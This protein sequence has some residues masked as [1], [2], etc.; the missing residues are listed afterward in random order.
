[1]K[2]NPFFVVWAILLL[3]V[4]QLGG[5]AKKPKIYISVDMEGIAHVVNAQTSAGQFDY[6]RGRKLMTAEVNAAIEGCLAAGAEV[7]IV[8]DSHGNAQNIIPE[9]LN[10]KALLIRS[11]PR[12]LLQMEGIDSTF[13]GV[14]FLGYHPKE[15]T[16]NANLSHTI[17]GTKFEEI[18]VNG[19]IVSEALFNAAVAGHFGVP[20]IMVCGDQHV[21]EEARKN[22]GPIETVITKESIGFLSAK[23]AHPRV[24]QMEIKQKAEK[25][26]K[27]IREMR[28]F[29]IKKP[30]TL[31]IVFKSI[32]DAETTAYLPWVKRINGKGIRVELNNI[33]EA[34]QF[35]TALFA[36][37]NR[38]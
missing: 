26:V 36:I 12:P 18:K 9:D 28:P 8:S 17:W 15:G 35:L 30:V 22:F 2:R 7:I 38:I 11:F 32:F 4:S 33:I 37:N 16:P 27:R 24:V 6:E 1:M 29:E 14:I 23:S 25:A 10:E 21:V 13:D 19:L 34:N 5:E 31:E 3:L 20:V